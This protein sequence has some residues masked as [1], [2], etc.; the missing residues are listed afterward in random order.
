MIY[1]KL[2]KESLLFAINALVVNKLRTLLSL[3]GI[4]IGIFAIISVFTV[5]DSMEKKI[6][7]SI[8]S[9]GDNVVYV[10]KWPWEFGDEYPWWKYMNRPLP[11]I[12]E[13]DEINK[14]SEK[15][16]ASAFMISTS[17][18][19]QYKKYY[20]ENVG[21]IAVSHDYDKVRSFE[22]EKGRYFSFF[23]SKS[24]RAL[25]IIG[26]NIA[27]T[28]F[29]G[30]NPIGKDI[31]VA[32]Y[33]L[34][35]IGVFKKEGE[36]IFNNSADNIVL[37]PINYVRKI[38]DI[39]NENMNPFI[40]I[41]AKEGIHNEELLEEL[42]GIMRAI[43]R[44]KPIADDD[45]ALNQTS[46]L[47]KGFNELF[48]IVDIAGLI[49]GGFS[50]LVGGFGIANI[51]FVSVKERTHIIGIQK[52][53]GAKNFFILLQFLYESVILCLIGGA[54]GLFLIYIGTLIVTYALDFNLGLSL[55]N[56]ISGLLISAF[57][58]LIS[59]I[60]PALSAAKLNPVEA[61]NSNM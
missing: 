23:E 20:A 8:E 51:M 48:K 7:D 22:L 36:D 29:G 42:K 21:I 15:A 2:L 40:M 25:A 54:I 31:K 19:V 16:E 37:A 57:I 33:K 28:L 41:K 47:T 45:F 53:L 61:I 59:G 39:R 30:I 60:A 58:G 1:L 27:N 9:L 18:T 26:S 6:K 13:L 4:T 32:G 24:G 11:T 52:S 43:R 55:W 14:R 3:L 49:I 10:Q 34:N 44:I 38:V 35:V 17:Q 12:K 50:I 46:M 5:I 56:I